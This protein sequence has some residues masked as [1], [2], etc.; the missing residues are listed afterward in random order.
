MNIKKEQFNKNKH[1]LASDKKILCYNSDGSIKFEFC[2]SK[3]DFLKT[4]KCPNSV[5]NAPI[6][7]TAFQSKHKASKEF[8]GCSFALIKWKP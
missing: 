2:G 3:I 1:K 6:K 7:Q 5:C 8:N 4:Y